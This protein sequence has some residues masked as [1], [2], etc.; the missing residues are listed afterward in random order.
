MIGSTEVCCVSV[1]LSR[2]RLSDRL[3]SIIGSM[4]E[5][6]QAAYRL[7]DIKWVGSRRGVRQ[8]CILSPLLFYI[9]TEES[10]VRLR[11]SGDLDEGWG[12]EAELFPLCR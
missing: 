9:Y 5:D 1:L 11:N 7:R 4:Y 8:G 6:T 12:G 3:V 10:A 2:M